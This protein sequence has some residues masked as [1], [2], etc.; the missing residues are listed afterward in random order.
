MNTNS[1]TTVIAMRVPQDMRARL[2][3][4][5]ELRGLDL[6]DI[7]IAGLVN[8]LATASAEEQAEM[9]RRLNGQG[10]AA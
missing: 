3:V 6:Q 8:E 2:R 9:A 7:A 1:P 5:A 4:L 10:Q